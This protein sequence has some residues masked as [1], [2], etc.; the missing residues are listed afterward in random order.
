MSPRWPIP[1][2]ATKST[3]RMDNVPSSRSRRQED[4]S[5]DR[6]TRPA[7]V[8]SGPRR[9]PAGGPMS[10]QPAQGVMSRCS[11]TASAGSSAPQL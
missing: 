11:L 4:A 7:G 9:V 6:N 3:T 5:A 8:R 1:I 10:D 2:G